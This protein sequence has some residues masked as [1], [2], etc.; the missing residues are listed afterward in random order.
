MLPTIEERQVTER[1]SKSGGVM[2]SVVVKARYSLVSA[3]DGSA[4]E[5]V[6]YGEGADTSDKATA[7]AETAAYKTAA[8]QAFCI[9]VEGQVDA[10]DDTPEIASTIS[11]DQ[12]IAAFCRL[13]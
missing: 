7:K 3:D 11:A 2:F 4:H 8:I 9:P 13:L 1:A 10:D 5:V 6:V 12:V